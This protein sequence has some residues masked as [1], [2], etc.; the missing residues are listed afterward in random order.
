MRRLLCRWC[1]LL[2]ALAVAC[3]V[4]QGHAMPQVD[5]LAGGARVSPGLVWGSEQ[6]LPF[7][8]QGQPLDLASFQP[9]QD[10][11]P[12]RS[13]GDGQHYTWAAFTLHNAS[14]ELASLVLNL[15]YA[16]I[17][18]ID[19]A[20][21]ARGQVVRVW[22][23]GNA[24]PFSTRPIPNPRFAFP[25][26]LAPAEDMGVLMRTRGYDG[27]LGDVVSVEDVFHWHARGQQE[28]VYTLLA[29][30]FT[31]AMM[32]YCLGQFIAQRDGLAISAL[33]YL[34]CLVAMLL[35]ARGQCYLLLGVD[36]PLVVGRIMRASFYTGISAM[37]LMLAGAMGMPRRL[38]VLCLWGGGAIVAVLVL[39]AVLAWQHPLDGMG[40]G[41]ALVALVW[42]ACCGVMF[43]AWRVHGL[44]LVR[45]HYIIWGP[46]AALV[47]FLVAR[48]FNWV[49]YSPRV[50]EWMILGHS[51]LLAL[52]VTA[53][54]LQM[55]ARVIT[56]EA[57]V[58]AQGEFLARMSHEIRTPMNAVLGMSQLLRDTSLDARQKS[59]VGTIFNA[60]NA[61]LGILNDILDFAKLEAGKLQIER[62]PFDLEDVAVECLGIFKLRAQELGV[63]LICTFDPAV[64]EWCEGDPTRVR[65]ILVNFVSNAVK[66]TQQ[67]E[68]ELS[69]TPARLMK[70]VRL[71]VRDTGEGVAAEEQQ[72]LF[73][74]FSQARLEIARKHG[75]TGLGLAICKQLVELMHGQIGVDS[76]PGEGATFW[77]ELPMPPA[78][79]PAA[80]A[81][82]RLSPKTLLGRRVLVVEDNATFRDYLA[83]L[84]RLWGMQVVAVD[85]GE[86]ALA[87]LAE[88]R[89]AFDLILL[90][91]NMP[92]EDGVSLANRITR[93]GLAP[94]SEMVL[95]TG[96]AVLPG[97]ALLRG[98]GIARV[99][100]KPVHPARLR[101][102]L[103]RVLTGRS[104]EQ[105]QP[106]EYRV[107]TPS[108]N[109]LLVDDNATN[110][111]VAGSMLKRLGHS[112]VDVENGRQALEAFAA[113]PERFDAV[114][115]DCEM[116][117]MDGWQATRE[118]RALEKQWGVR[119]SIPII[120]LTAH[121]LLSEREHCMQA[122]MDEVLHKPVLMDSL[123]SALQRRVG[124][125]ERRS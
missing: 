49:P 4:S 50:F 124:A 45:G 114:L 91:W 47:A 97:E 77:C 1:Q 41:D 108:L 56:A 40:W 99:E 88:A 75:G 43:W 86:A 52:G 92:G 63:E 38:P 8:A 18:E 25:V 67:G 22:H 16:Q 58:R 21:V 27:G 20:L 11:R 5:W 82:S 2:F 119:E 30:G 95:L 90:D 111:M 73:K 98:S 68:I 81:R 3:M 72:L 78:E 118:I 14:G 96:V 83:S 103:I 94:A 9:W 121:A 109:I 116:P 6:A 74:R 13:A 44:R 122:G 59:Y 54:S 84:G 102:L 23:T 55:K 65:Q 17:R 66:F 87:A 53:R 117:V 80:A 57:E 48:F 79:P 51:L 35:A 85:G 26:P 7:P 29:M 115:M 120:A 125:G 100:E 37:I 32:I 62:I 110:R 12:P 106:P 24:L 76:P 34:G 123:A 113:H 89:E 104:H 39:N 69:V 64:S 112:F 107:A 71:S 28:G 70:G 61:L 31:L 15:D 10:A 36:D 19:V 33:I 46:Y 93:E 42:L 101:E 60:S 105:G